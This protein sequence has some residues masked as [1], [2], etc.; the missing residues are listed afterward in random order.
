MIEK[1][2]ET[3]AE[4]GKRFELKTVLPIKR[5][6]LIIFIFMTFLYESFTLK[7]FVY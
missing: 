2:V 3:F 1:I 7:M 5:D 6:L 4:D